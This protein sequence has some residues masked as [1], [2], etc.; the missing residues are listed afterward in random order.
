M[1]IELGEDEVT[2]VASD[3]YRLSVRKL[4]PL[5]FRGHPRSLLVN[6]VELVDLGRWAAAAERIT[7]ESNP[8]GTALLR[9]EDATRELRVVE[10]EF[11]AY[12][13]MLDD[14]P[15]PVCR[16]VVDRL[17]LL[18]LLT[19][20]MVALDIKSGKLTVSEV[21]A[22]EIG[23]LEVVGAGDVRIGFTAAVLAAALSVSVGPDVLLEISEPARPVTVR[24]AD[25]GTFTTL[26]M[27]ARLDG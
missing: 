15:A 23:S 16:V 17:R 4:Q 7:V 12:Q 11:P 8:N 6:A 18:E 19:G 3:R 26:V 5:S 27:P 14:L 25:Q 21:A 20:G 24:S 2:L 13:V 9:T 1:L 10:D 22:G